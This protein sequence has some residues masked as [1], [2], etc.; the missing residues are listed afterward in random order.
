MAN[1]L[2]NKANKYARD[3]VSGKIPAC[4]YVRL[5]CQRHLDD[6][7]KSKEKGFKY[8]FNRTAA[9]RV[10]RFIQMMPHTK[11]EWAFKRQLITLEPWQLFIISV[12]F[13]WQVKKSGLRRFRE[14]YTEIPRKNGKSAMGAAPMLGIMIRI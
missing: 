3:I 7:V 8:K 9:E 14:V 10:C 5:A 1:P 11:G 13:G 4:R 2:V 12:A 6:L